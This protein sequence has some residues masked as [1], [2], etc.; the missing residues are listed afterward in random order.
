[1]KDRLN[2]LF[3]MFT[4]A[5][6]ATRIALVVGTIVLITLGGATSWL[7]NRKEYVEIWSGLTPAE[8]SEY[9]KALA[10]AGI[11]FRSSPPPDN[12]I[13]VDIADR[14]A[15]EQQVAL[16]GYTPSIKG[17]QVADGGAASAF[18]SARAR[19]QMSD[20]R[21][22]QECEVQLERLQFVMRATVTTSGTEASPFTPDKSST[23]SVTL[24]LRPGEVL[25]GA[26]S[27]T[28]AS[29]VRGR[30]NVPMENIIVVDEQGN[31]L[32]DGMDSGGGMS[33]NDI[34]AYKQRHD[35]SLERKANKLLERSLGPGLGMVTVI[36]KWEYEESE[37]IEEV[38]TPATDPYYESTS[39]STSDGSS[40]GPGGPAGTSSNITQDFGNE[41]AGTGGSSSG[42]ATHTSDRTEKRS[43]VGR[44]TTHTTQNTPQLQRMSISLV[45]DESQAAQLENISSVIKAA[46]GYDE[47]TDQFDSQVMT[48][49]SLE[50]DEDGN[51]VVP[52][53]IEPAD[54]P[55]AYLEMGLKYGVEILAAIGFLVVLIKSLKGGSA[56]AGGAG[57]SGGGAGPAKSP[58]VPG[59]ITDANPAG[60]TEEEIANIDPSQLA[61]TQVEDLVRN[62]PEKVS[63]ILAYWASNSR[64]V[65]AGR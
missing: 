50:R 58:I 3:Q 33:G 59:T 27:R 35:T 48:L 16:A 44:K 51:V 36:S 55:N 21:E 15:A 12:G 25:D 61:R 13:W 62:H 7:A 54:P 2:Q 41:N 22:W 31:L 47:T 14:D 34:F 30:F 38:A 18:L 23:V 19:E 40:S 52:A 63:E 64:T 29:L 56:V 57:A 46:V 60:I 42:S 65:G 53:A 49:A 5:N 43:A 10:G 26:K 37:S 8:S 45:I 4:A 17:I 6:S 24:G 11:S 1:M 32:H 28:V 39:K 20:K 9:K